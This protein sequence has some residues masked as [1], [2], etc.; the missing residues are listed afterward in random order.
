MT[1]NIANAT[2]W[3]TERWLRW[4][5]WAGGCPCEEFLACAASPAGSRPVS[6]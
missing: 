4:K 6:G 2:D 1:L 3:Y 5:Q